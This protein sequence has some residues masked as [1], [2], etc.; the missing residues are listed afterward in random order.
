METRPK[1]VNH[2]LRIGTSTTGSARGYLLGRLLKMADE[3]LRPFDK[4]GK[5]FSSRSWRDWNSL[6]TDE[7]WMRQ[8]LRLAE[9]GRGR[10]S[11]NPMVGAIIV[12]GGQDCRKGLPCQS[13]GTPCRNL[14]LQQA[15]EKA[16]GA[17]YISIWNLAPISEGHH[18]AL[19]G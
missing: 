1:G 12:K 13:R 17:R 10:T 4:E 6:M 14:A 9:K 19:L 16:R 5:I 7:Q 11:P 15:G 3:S 2:S 18:P 8:V